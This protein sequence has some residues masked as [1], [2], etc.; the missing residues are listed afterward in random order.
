MME[1]DP[2][3]CHAFPGARLTMLL[4]NKP[5]L[6]ERLRQRLEDESERVEPELLLKIKP[7]IQQSEP[8]QFTGVLVP[9]CHCLF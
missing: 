2:D 6:L 8:E 9:L 7:F 5:E 3:L 1:L 4:D